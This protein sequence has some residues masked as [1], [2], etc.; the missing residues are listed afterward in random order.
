M[1]ELMIMYAK[2]VPEEFLI[3][4]LEESLTSYK[5]NRNEE[6]KERLKCSLLV[7]TTRLITEKRSTE[8][9]MKQFKERMDALKLFENRNQ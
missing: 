2:T 5:I 6:T 3:N 9:T 1:N 8:S 4:D 7:L